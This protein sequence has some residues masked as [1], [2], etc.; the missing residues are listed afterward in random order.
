MLSLVLSRSSRNLSY[1]SL[2][3]QRCYHS[4]KAGAV[5]TAIA[6][7]LRKSRGHGFRGSPRAGLSADDSRE[8]YLVEHGIPHYE[9]RP[10]YD[11]ERNFER[12]PNRGGPR[13]ST[14]RWEGRGKATVRGKTEAHELRIRLGKRLIT[15]RE[16]Q[17]GEYT[18]KPAQSERSYEDRGPKISDRGGR[19]FDHDPRL[20]A[21]RKAE[22]GE[23]ERSR[24]SFEERGS[25]Y[26]ERKPFREEGE[27]P[28]QWGRPDTLN[29][30]SYTGRRERDSE[31]IPRH[32]RDFK[33]SFGRKGD[34]RG[35][36]SEPPGKESGFSASSSGRSKD[37]QSYGSRSHAR[38][39]EASGRELYPSLSPRKVSPESSF[40]NHKSTEG[41]LYNSKSHRPS[42]SGGSDRHPSL[43]SSEG[44]STS[45]FGSASSADRRPLDRYTSEPKF[46]D[47]SSKYD[48]ASAAREERLSSHGLKIT[49]AFDSRIPLSI[50]YT[51]PASEFLYGTSVVEAALSSQREPRR[52]LY[53]LYIYTG[54]N[55]EDPDQ[56]ARL[57]RLARRS[58][59]EVVRAGKEW[60][61]VM[62]KMSA[63]RPHN[64]YIL[65]A[66][67][68][69][70][71][72][73][74]RLGQLTTVDGQ[75]GFEVTLDY[76]SR[77]EA[78]VNGT[79]N[80]IRIPRSKN[81]RKPL[82][83]LLDS[84]VDP[85][86]L[87]GIIR[88]A[89]FLGVT[90]I[91][92]SARNS[93]SFTPV[94]LKASAGASEDVTVFM[95]NKPAG[96]VVDSKIAGWKVFAAV[97]PTKKHDPGMPASLSTDQLDDPLSKDPCIL[98]LGSE[99]EG[100]RWNLRS[101]ADVDLYIE[102][103]RQSRTVDSLNVSVAAGILCNSFLKGSQRKK[104]APIR[105]E[106]KHE[107]EKENEMSMTPQLF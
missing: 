85:G 36:D 30:T 98:M 63:G 97:A 62:D 9:E 14:N 32:F 10:K 72:P 40:G 15:G 12:K 23:P 16:E 91:A 20:F 28:A 39:S 101:K 66:S 47:R 44:L 106:Q 93:A 33:E 96:F 51:T 19:D 90:A 83:L 86:N 8:K 84:I 77:E 48:G 53:K 27:R 24:R 99:G 17:G 41:S 65:E 102:G 82:V 37:K 64:G 75:D 94:V 13:E 73:V 6:K 107:P 54:E 50:P 69:P 67:P 4:G 89:S 78:A 34:I 71:L 35:R 103:S 3:L 11:R 61:R 58:G 38:P 21:N 88:T 5:H 45:N 49:Q 31:D 100:L 59:I 2:I 52:K 46:I 25:R 43:S 95:V 1:Q 104:A 105:Q 87:G 70:K 76:Q 42:K 81:G 92:I 68:L 55:R 79:S 18:G 74:T 56:D 29:S 22:Y 60:I 26:P 80:F 57:E 7:G